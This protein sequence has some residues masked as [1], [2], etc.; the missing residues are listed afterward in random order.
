M[1]NDINSITLTGR[2]GKDPEIRHTSGGTAV[3]NLAVAVNSYDKRE[4]DNTKTNWIDVV[5][6]GKTAEFIAN[7]IAKGCRVAIQGQLDQAKWQ[8]GQGENRQK[9]QIL[10]R[11]FTPIDWADDNQASGT[12]QQSAPAAAPAPGPQDPN[13]DIPF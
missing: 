7:K 2:L 8:N 13:D 10:G 1:A 6:F 3:V 4:E 12:R 9:H 5:F 11:E